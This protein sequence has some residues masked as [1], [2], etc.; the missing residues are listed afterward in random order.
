MMVGSIT[1]MFKDLAISSCTLATESNQ[2]TGNITSGRFLKRY[3]IPSTF[4][5]NTFSWSLIST[6]TGMED[7]GSTQ[8]ELLCSLSLASTPN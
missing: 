1:S 6:F 7:F 8:K 5:S 4:L 2:K 3:S